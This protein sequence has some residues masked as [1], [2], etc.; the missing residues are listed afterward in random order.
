MSI[1]VWTPEQREAIERISS[2]RHDFNGPRFMALTGPAGS[3]K[4]SVLEG[5]RERVAVFVEISEE[6]IVETLGA[7]F[8][9][10]RFPRL[11]AFLGERVGE[12]F[13][14]TARH[15]PDSANPIVRDWAQPAAAERAGV[16]QPDHLDE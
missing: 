11:A 1:D 14:R 16:G 9:K 3:G 4:T 2:W 6:G 5:V 15:S 13:Q 12:L 10:P 7:R 8:E